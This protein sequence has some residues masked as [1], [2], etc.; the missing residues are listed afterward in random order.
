MFLSVP[1]FSKGDSR[2]GASSLQLGLD[3]TRS[4]L[5]LDS[6][7][8]FGTREQSLFIYWCYN[9]KETSDELNVIPSLIIMRNHAHLVHAATDDF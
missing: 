5:R 7:S 2:D 4:D 6:H 1:C 9:I 8:R 3:L